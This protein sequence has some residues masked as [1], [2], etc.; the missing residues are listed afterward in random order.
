MSYTIKIMRWESDFFKKKIGEILIDYPLKDEIKIDDHFDF[1]IAKQ[2]EASEIRIEGYTNS[3]REEKIVFSKHLEE[4]DT[5]LLTT[6]ILDS[7]KTPIKADLLYDLA[8]ESGKHS[9]FKL[10]ALFKDSEF[11]KLYQC[12]VINS[13]NK[14][15]GHKVF[16]MLDKE[17]PIAFV[18]LNLKDNIGQI[19]LI[20]VDKHYQGQGLGKQLIKHIESYCVNHT[21]PILNIPTQAH[22]KNATGFYT[23]L[24]Y[25]IKQQEIINHFWLKKYYDSF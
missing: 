7:D 16:Y 21:I 14:T 17:V 2:K 23:K 13:I 15:F 24:G 25:H 19:G 5:P 3:Y 10:D 6:T 20:A 18:T 12:W 22:N 1:I 4:L 11:E 8:Y 9:R